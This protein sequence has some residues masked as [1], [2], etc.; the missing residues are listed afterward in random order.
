M[1]TEAKD[2]PSIA[3]LTGDGDA[4]PLRGNAFLQAWGTR[5]AKELLSFMQL[6]M[7]PQKPG[8]LP[9]QEYLDIVA[10]ILQQ[11]GAAA[12]NQAFTANTAV[13]INSVLSA[14][15]PAAPA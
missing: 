7:P 13:A 2:F 1:F 10:F 5:S 6:T 4:A 12:G 11:N 14:P 3:D 9:P 15:A 8:G